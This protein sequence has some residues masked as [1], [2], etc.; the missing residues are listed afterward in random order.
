MK[1]RF[2]YVLISTLLVSNCI[3]Q[4]SL[5]N[6][7][8]HGS[9]NN[10]IKYSNYIHKDYFMDLAYYEGSIT[11]HMDSILQIELERN[12]EVFFRVLF[13]NQRGAILAINPGDTIEIDVTIAK[14]SILKK[15]GAP[16]YQIDLSKS[17]Y[18]AHNVYR[19][20]FNPISKTFSSIDSLINQSNSDNIF[21]LYNSCKK[22]IN[23]KLQIWDS[24][25]NTNNISLPVYNLYYSDTKAGMNRY[26]IRHF[27]NQKARLKT[28]T[29]LNL[30]DS[31]I[32]K[33]FIEQG[34]ADKYLL[35]T[36]IGRR[37]HE[38]YLTEKIKS[39]LLIK[40]TLLKQISESYFFLFDRTYRESAW[41]NSVLLPAIISPYNEN[42]SNKANAIVLL[43]YYPNSVYLKKMNAIYDSI[44]MVRQKAY[45]AI[46]KSYQKIIIH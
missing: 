44:K 10:T 40:D 45:V 13:N 18:L 42:L 30:F 25:L 38:T 2:I 5:I 21:E 12:S 15:S 46:K 32:Q 3:G 19:E 20:R 23:N 1:I 43:R 7:R 11:K 28:K 8:I 17:N 33:I 34:A 31:L 16:I 22:I 27:L 4:K 26:L 35:K 39:N 36:Y 9:K 24:L 14:D 37:F 41:G 6:I 29:R